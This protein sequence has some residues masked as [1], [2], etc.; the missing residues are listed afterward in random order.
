VNEELRLFRVYPTDRIFSILSGSHTNNTAINMKFQLLFAFFLYILLTGC[1]GDR[2]IEFSNNCHNAWSFVI[3]L[4]RS[5]A[6]T[7]IPSIR[8]SYASGMHNF[9]RQT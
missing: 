6:T 9:E 1:G 8:D 5:T 7:M 3:G 4:N 2:N